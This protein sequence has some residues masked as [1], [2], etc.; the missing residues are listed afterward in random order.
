MKLKIL[1]KRGKIMNNY[2][3]VII[4]NDNLEEKQKKETIKKIEEFISKRG[5]LNRTD[6]LGSKRMA[7][8]IKKQKTGYYC[9]FYFNV[10][11]N[12]IPELERICR[13]T[14]EIIK[15]ITVRIDE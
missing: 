7:Y 12:V 10:E 1:K 2:E 6:T 15:F 11:P 8:E 4:I 14:E 3:S 13:I 9:I 5:K